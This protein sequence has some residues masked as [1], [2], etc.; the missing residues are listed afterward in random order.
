MAFAEDFKTINGTEYKNATVTRVEPDGIAIKF[1]DGIVKLPFVELPG[2]VQ[3]RFGYNADTAAAYA[4][5]QYAA[6]Q[7]AQ[8]EAA[9]SK[10]QYRDSC[11]RAVTARERTTGRTSRRS[12]ESRRLVFEAT[13]KRFVARAKAKSPCART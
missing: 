6:A 5:D 11:R 4:A 10:R 3:K 2:D 13:R 7:Q 1:S 12:G 8:K 9:E